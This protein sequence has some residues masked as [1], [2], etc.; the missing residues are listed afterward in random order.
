[1]PRLSFRDR[2]FSPPVARAMMSPLGIVLAGAGAAAGVLTGGGV[3]A[4]V[5]LGA[6]AWAGRVA[7]A[8]PRSPRPERI[9]PF[10]LNE[11][12]RRFVQDALQ[13]QNRFH[14]AVGGARAGP[15]RDRLG[16]IADRVD[17]GVEECWR[18]AQRGQDLADARRKLD[19]R[20][21]EREIAELESG[22]SGAPTEGSAVEEMAEAWRAQLASAERMDTV[23]ADAR[24]RL[25][26]LNARL[27][28]A[29]ARAVELSVHAGDAGAL[30]GLGDDVDHLVDD[31]EALRQALDAVRSAER[32]G[33]RPA[34]GTT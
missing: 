25:R 32:G 7:A 6:V 30:S 11:P 21:A 20:E 12:W 3:V 18:I 9:D 2:F 26:L 8:I 23:I 22:A 13:A 31:M 10:T 16:G 33:G 19:T 5:A 27:D 1:M 24:D 34:T 17:T 14:S 29:V 15:L 4:A 28:E